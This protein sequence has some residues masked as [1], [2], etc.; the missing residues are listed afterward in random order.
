M[1]PVFFWYMF[2]NLTNVFVLQIW[3]PF[4][5]TNMKVMV[6]KIPWDPSLLISRVSHGC[7]DHQVTDITKC[8]H[9]HLPNLLWTHRHQDMPSH[10]TVHTVAVKALTVPA[11]ALKGAVEEAVIVEMVITE[12]VAEA[13]VRRVVVVKGRAKARNA[14]LAAWKD[15]FNYRPC[16]ELPQ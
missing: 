12:A 5:L 15:Q 6:T 2:F 4:Q 7:Q 13:V 16:Q 14:R 9:T 8:R 3:L 11:A 10:F 1:V